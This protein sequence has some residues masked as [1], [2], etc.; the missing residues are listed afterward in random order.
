VEQ[1]TISLC[2]HHWVL[3]EPHNDVIDAVCKRCSAQ[4][5]YPARLE[6][7]ERFDDYQELTVGTVG[8]KPLST[9]YRPPDEER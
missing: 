2:Q 6:A 7:T 1:T 9:I 4:R 3:T 8:G 5:E